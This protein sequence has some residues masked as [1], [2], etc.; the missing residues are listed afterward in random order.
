MS[1]HIIVFCD[2]YAASCSSLGTKWPT[3]HTLSSKFKKRPT[4]KR[5]VF[6]LCDLRQLMQKT[7]N[8]TYQLYVT[9]FRFTHTRSF[10]RSKKSTA[11]IFLHIAGPSIQ[12]EI[13]SHGRLHD[14]HLLLVFQIGTITG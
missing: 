6:T 14:P 2:R 10:E 5:F 12:K 9:E 8:N 7:G 13:L 4:R 11:R 3:L 1:Y